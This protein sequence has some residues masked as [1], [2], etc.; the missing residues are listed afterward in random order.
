MLDERLNIYVALG[1]RES[2][3]WRRVKETFRA[4]GGGWKRLGPSFDG[5]PGCSQFPSPITHTARALPRRSCRS[6]SHT[7]NPKCA[8][9][10]NL[11]GQHQRSPSA[12]QMK[13]SSP[14]K[15]SKDLP[16]YGKR[17]T[18]G[19]TQGNNCARCGGTLQTQT[20]P[21]DSPPICIGKQPRHRALRTRS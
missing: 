8:T 7:A 6:F 17:A 18:A 19:T 12:G 5:F 21:T 13:R 4:Y 2:R 1:K 3:V 11:A 9:T 20:L 16:A 10:L 15:G 14:P